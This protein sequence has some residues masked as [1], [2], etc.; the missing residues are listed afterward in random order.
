MKTTLNPFMYL[1]DK[2]FM[3]LIEDA[4][5]TPETFT[6]PPGDYYVAGRSGG[7]SGSAGAGGVGELFENWFTIPQATNIT[8]LVGAG[9][10]TK[11]NGGNGGNDY[12]LSNYLFTV[13]PDPSNA[14]VTFNTGTI[15]GNSTLVPT[16]TTVTYTVSA[17]GYVTQTNSALIT[18]DR[19]IE[20][21][22]ALQSCTLTINPTPSDATVTFSID[23]GQVSQAVTQIIDGFTNFSSS[24]YYDINN[25]VSGNSITVPYGTPVTYSVSKTGFPTVTNTVTVT[26]T[27]T[28]NVALGS[29]LTITPTPS[30]ATVVLTASGYTQ[31]G[32]SIIVPNNTS[33]AYTVSK[34]GYQTV[35]NT[36]TVTTDNNIA[37][38][39]L[40][41]HT[42]SVIPNP[43]DATVTLTAAG[44]TQFGNSI[45]VAHGTSVHY[46]VS[47]TNYTSVG[48]DV[49]VNSTQTIN[50]QI[51][52]TPG[53]TIFETG[54]V[55]SYNVTLPRG[56]YR[57]ILRATGGAGGS[58]VGSASGG[59]G[60]K[61]NLTVQ[62]F[63]VSND[64]AITA[65]LHGIGDNGGTGGSSSGSAGGNGGAGAYPTYIIGLTE[66]Y[67]ANGGAGGGGAGGTSTAI[68][69]A[70]GGGGGGYYIYSYR[71]YPHTM[72]WL[73]I[74]GQSGGNG[75]MNGSG[76][77]GN[78]GDTVNFP[79]L[80]GGKAD[81]AWN[82]GD[83]G[84]AAYGGG[85]NGGQGGGASGGGGEGNMQGNGGAGGGGAG[86]DND[87]GGGSVGT[88]TGAYHSW[89]DAS[90]VKTT[91]TDVSAE[92]SSYGIPANCGRGGYPDQAG[93]TGY[94]KIV[95]R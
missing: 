45:T 60:G 25:L 30:D 41:L 64:T 48:D 38:S 19:T 20:V 33:V 67:Y 75:N 80:Y 53:V 1:P 10:K 66:T 18:A 88:T 28:I 37:V 27:R 2:E 34:S 3:Y 81:G 43:S 51:N 16:G 52:L 9:G 82:A 23:F 58:S 70:G 78:N 8:Y 89:T 87:A 85:G 54:T 86:G 39:L 7:G 14:T 94:I 15:V 24:N 22:L 55:G 72:Y 36:T 17:P 21:S 4:M 31:S 91:P 40:E 61:G 12:N 83:P 46:N 93:T 71:T 50:V 6:L 56:N 76:G 65:V 57:A 77:A 35:S 44:Y 13:I 74:S 73:T 11:L 47:K 90:N 26:E 92:N 62:D 32:N 95:T 5:D 59:C 79:S 84:H 63:T 68:Y 29:I 49:T 69:G 42:F